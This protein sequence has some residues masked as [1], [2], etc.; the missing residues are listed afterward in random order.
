MLGRKVDVIEFGGGLL[1]RMIWVDREYNFVLRYERL[2]EQS[3]R[4]EVVR[5]EYNP[6]L[7]DDTFAFDPPPGA[8]GYAGDRRTTNFGG[9]LGSGPGINATGLSSAE[10]SARGLRGA[11]DQQHYRPGRHGV[12][13]R[14]E[15]RAP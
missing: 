12:A 9:S 13:V 11:P 1:P 14:R 3:V 8:R 4:A 15:L 2:G 7:P 10:L 5:L 6:S